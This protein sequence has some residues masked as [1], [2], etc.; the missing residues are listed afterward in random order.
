MKRKPETTSAIKRRELMHHLKSKRVIALGL[1]L[2]VVGL[3][4]YI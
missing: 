1:L 2:A 3:G 4:T